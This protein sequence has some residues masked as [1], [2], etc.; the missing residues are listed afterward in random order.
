MH[1]FNYFSLGEKSDD[2]KSAGS[3]FA[4]KY[5]LL[6]N[7]Y[8]LTIVAD[9]EKLY[10]IF[11]AL[12]P[13]L[14][15][16]VFFLSIAKFQLQQPLKV[17]DCFK[18]KLSNPYFETEMANIHPKTFSITRFRNQWYNYYSK[19]HLMVIILFMSTTYTTSP[20]LRNVVKKSQKM[21]YTDP[22]IVNEE[23]GRSEIKKNIPCS[24]P[25][26]IH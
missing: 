2:V 16:L 5:R 20:Y 25:P 26:R 3:Y 14:V 19:G 24:S 18:V 11:I 7:L 8:W 13:W 22:E 15:V 21:L 6:S 12:S 4:Q 9:Q 10:W 23:S 1:L 17:T